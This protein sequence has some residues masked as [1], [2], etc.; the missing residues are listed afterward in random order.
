MIAHRSA[1]D[2]ARSLGVVR[3][4]GNNFLVPCPN[5]FHGKG[6]GDQNPSCSIRD[7]IDGRIVVNCFGKCDPRDVIRA[8]V[9]VGWIERSEQP[10]P[11]LRQASGV[12]ATPD[13]NTSGTIADLVERGWQP[14]I[15]DYDDANGVTVYHKVRLELF[16]SAGVRIGRTFRQRRRD[17]NG[18]HVE[19]LD[20][21]SPVPY[22]LPEIVANPE[23][24]IW[25]LEGEK[26]AD[27]VAATGRLATSV[28][29]WTAEVISN[30]QGR[31][32]IV[33]P[34]NDDAGAKL[35]AK[36]DAALRPVAKSVRIAKPPVLNPARAVGWDMADYLD[37][38]G[39]MADI[40]A[41]LQQRDGPIWWEQ[42]GLRGSAEY[43]VKGILHPGDFAC[44]YGESYTGKSH[45]ALDMAVSIAT[46]QPW[47]GQRVR[48]CSVL[49]VA[50]EGRRGF[51]NRVAARRQ[52]LP[53]QHVPL[54]VWMTTLDFSNPTTTGQLIH[55]VQQLASVAPK[56]GLIVF[57][58][59]AR[60]IGVND[61]N[62][63][64]GMGAIISASARIQEETGACTLWVHHVG[65][66]FGRGPR[67]HSSLYAALDTG[68]RVTRDGDGTSKA[69]IEK[70]KDGESGLK[71]P[72]RIVP[73]T[74]GIDEDGDTITAGV[75]EFM[76]ISPNARNR[77]EPKGHAAKALN[78]LRKLVHRVGELKPGMPGIPENQPSVSE[79]DWRQECMRVRLGQGDDDSEQKA[80]ARA[81]RSL[82]QG[83]HTAHVTGQVWPAE[84]NG[85][86]GQTRTKDGHVRSADRTDTD[87]PPKGMSNVRAEDMSMSD[88]V[89]E[90]WVDEHP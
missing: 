52:Q 41:K 82:K 36:A 10:G 68:I 6:L 51:E 80:F 69:E 16:D 35:A 81:S 40:E 17:A 75:I 14:T 87:I 7:G 73:H 27:A 5:P 85:H 45:L 62:S 12:V 22:R 90:G 2:I 33:V 72:F 30:F 39:S 37:C 20:G 25:V 65:K 46:G 59:M 77:P 48:Q 84:N 4:S 19:N 54:A 32:V 57:D 66:D 38:G 26:C 15:Y 55:I 9:E 71:W 88:G 3:R 34:D 79:A 78:L 47:R 64:N 63:S 61:E 11:A 76:D 60:A 74:L 13:P 28:A 50:M 31:D 29:K 43:I 8:A 1:A 83:G 70:Q 56:I 21:V 18:R 49:Y 67:G 86:A 42:I 53:G 44:V 89:V 58:T 23:P 24:L